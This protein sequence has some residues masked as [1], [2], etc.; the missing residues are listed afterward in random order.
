MKMLQEVQPKND[1]EWAECV[2]ATNEAKSATYKRHGYS[3]YHHVFGRDP[4]VA[5]DL[6]QGPIDVT[7][8]TQ[9]LYDSGAERSVAIRMAARKAAL[10]LQDSDDLR[11]ALAARP[12]PAKRFAVGDKVAYWRRGKGQGFKQGGARWHGRATV[13]GFQGDNLIVSHRNNF[14]RCAPEQ[15]RHATLAE[16]TGDTLV[17]NVLRGAQAV[18]QQS[19]HQGMVD[20]TQSERPPTLESVHDVVKRNTL[21]ESNQFHPAPTLSSTE[22]DME[23]PH[24]MTGDDAIDVDGELPSVDKSIT[25]IETTTEPSTTPTTKRRL[26]TKLRV[27]TFERFVSMR[28]DDARSTVNEMIADRNVSEAG[29]DVLWM[30]GEPLSWEALAAQ[31]TKGRREINFRELSVQEKALVDEAKRT[32]WSTMEETGSV[33]L[34]TD[35]SR[36]STRVPTSIR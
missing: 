36:C 30:S 27:P 5:S 17:E 35:Q 12:R 22:Q 10:E 26:W 14:L 13:V 32:E 34:L 7:A 33:L 29:A 15:V 4:Y 16:V 31:A 6:L 8:A 28:P 3:S 24:P 11:R 2:D 1:L 23:H 19:G 18:L 9:P 21:I 20:L 25:Q